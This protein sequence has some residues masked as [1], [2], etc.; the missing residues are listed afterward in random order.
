MAQ[1]FSH[2]EKIGTLSEN[3]GV[4][5]L[6]ASRLTIGGQQHITST[7]NLTMSG[8]VQNTMYMIYAVVSAGT[9]ILVQSTNT[10]STGPAGYTAWKLVGSFSTNATAATF[11]SFNDINAVRTG[12]GAPVARTL[13]VTYQAE[14]DG[15][16]TGR[17]I[18]NNSVSALTR[19]DVFTDAS[20]TPTTGVTSA[21]STGH[22][23][24][25]FWNGGAAGFSVPI[26]KGN[27]YTC[28]KVAVV[29]TQGSTET[30][31]WTPLVEQPAIKDL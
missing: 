1:V 19:W 27:Y 22:S 8:L 13:G 24:A 28:G 7:L 2:L 31:I 3:T 23:N 10:N 20:P 29:S 12:L 9:V 25:Q 15:F 14:V 26:K 18:G 16:F 17:I 4:I 5:S 11:L 21:Y 30:L 6:T